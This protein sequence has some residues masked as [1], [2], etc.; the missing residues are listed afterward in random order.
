MTQVNRCWF[1]YL[2]QKTKVQA[3]DSKEK[4]TVLDCIAELW[5]SLPLAVTDAE[6]L[7]G[8]RETL[9]EFMI[10]KSFEAIYSH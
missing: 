6:I 2:E 1:S 7:Y 10:A 4:E 5:D 3:A 9:C 8:F